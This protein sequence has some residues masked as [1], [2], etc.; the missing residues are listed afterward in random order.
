M[1]YRHFLFVCGVVCRWL[2]EQSTC[3][4]WYDAH[5]GCSQT[6]GARFFSVC[7]LRAFGV[8]YAFNYLFARPDNWLAL[9]TLLALLSPS[10]CIHS[11]S[12]PPPLPLPPPL[13]TFFSFSSLPSSSCF[14]FV[15]VTC[16]KP[17][18]SRSPWHLPLVHLRISDFSPFSVYFGQPRPTR[19][20]SHYHSSS[21]FL[22]LALSLF[23][24]SE[25][26]ASLLLFFFFRMMFRHTFAYLDWNHFA[27]FKLIAIS[28]FIY[29]DSLVIWP[30]FAYSFVSSTNQIVF[31]VFFFLFFFSFQ[32]S[33]YTFLGE[34]SLKVSRACRV[35][36]L[37]SASTRK[38]PWTFTLIH[39]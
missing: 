35:C 20:V 19:I 38:F 4:L 21:S 10:R 31:V 32:F 12:Y 27:F 24:T 39:F 13:F 15:C 7:L 14:A 28:R 8:S 5:T 26:P 1:L 23:V 9:P 17:Q 2:I 34:H 25:L 36:L 6:N 16:R 37:Q 29:R 11:H 3:P 33:S 18:A 30:H 22:P